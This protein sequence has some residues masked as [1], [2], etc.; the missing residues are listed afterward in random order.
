MQRSGTLYTVLFAGA[1]CVF[2]S[3]II[4]VAAVGLRDRQEANVLLDKQRKVLVVSGLAQLKPRATPEEVAVL[5][6]VDTG[7]V[8]ARVVELESGEYTAEGEF[9]ANTYDQQDALSTRT[10]IGFG[11]FNGKTLYGVTFEHL[12]HGEDRGAGFPLPELFSKIDDELAAGRLVIISL[13]SPGGHWHMWVIYEI[14]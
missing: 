3:L 11:D 2:F 5:F 13:N 10:D 7:R 6:D 12:F 4:S 14:S 1:V 9:D 8:R